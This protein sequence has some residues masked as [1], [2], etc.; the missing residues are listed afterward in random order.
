MKESSTKYARVT[1][2]DTY[3]DVE[4]SELLIECYGK[5][6]VPKGQGQKRHKWR[7]IYCKEV[8]Q[9]RPG[10]NYHRH[11]V[12]PVV[13]HR[14]RQYPIVGKGQRIVMKDQQAFVKGELGKRKG[15]MVSAE[16]DGVLHSTIDWQEVDSPHQ[17]PG[18]TETHQ[19]P[20]MTTPNISNVL[21]EERGVS[22]SSERSHVCKLGVCEVTETGD[23]IRLA[24]GS[25]NHEHVE[26]EGEREAH[27]CDPQVSERS[28]IMYQ[29]F[30]ALS[31]STSLES[32]NACSL[33]E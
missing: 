30:D 29:T 21:L 15:H 22:S 27:A 11:K 12:C 31:D 14:L 4:Y 24:M 6:K 25:D 10:L 7:C 1:W 3:E 20:V 23:T 33:W 9:C 2:I 28:P 8:F 16:E 26:V 32:D 5:C 19:P 13:G 18:D 17:C